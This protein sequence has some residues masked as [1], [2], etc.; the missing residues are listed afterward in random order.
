MEA[1]K[2]RKPK[3]QEVLDSIDEGIRKAQADYKEAFESH[4]CAGPEHLMTVY[5]FQAILRLTKRCGYTYGLSLEVPLREL[6][7]NLP[8]PKPREARMKGRCDLSLRDFDDKPRVAIEVKKYASECYK[9]L[10]RLKRLLKQGFEFSVLASCWFEQV[11]DN[12]EKKAKQAL[13]KKIQS[14]YEGMLVYSRKS[15]GNP[16]IDLVKSPI[17]KLSLSSEPPNED[18]EWMWRPVCFLISYKD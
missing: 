3:Q 13:K 6:K 10:R 2:M 7:S 16:S 18:E 1:A 9:D 11:E 15:S 14:L 8:G 4:I 5:I 17:K 12:N